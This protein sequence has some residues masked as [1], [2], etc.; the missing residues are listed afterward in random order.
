MWQ[1]ASHVSYEHVPFGALC[2]YNRQTNTLSAYR[3]SSV[4]TTIWSICV[5]VY[6]NK[7]SKTQGG[8]FGPSER[9]NAYINVEFCSSVKSI[10]YI[11]KYVN[12]GSDMA[13]FQIHYTDVNT[14]WLNDNDEIMRYQIGRYITSMKLSGI[15]LVSQSMNWIQ[16]LYI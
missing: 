12:K 9:F 1:V 7:S 4:G 6:V 15:S 8:P 3:F 16:Q 13:V 2:F 5:C 10:K 11:F 14:P